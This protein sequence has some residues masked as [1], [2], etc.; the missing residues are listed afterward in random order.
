MFRKIKKQ[1]EKNKAEIISAEYGKKEEGGNFPSEQF[2]VSQLAFLGDSVYEVAVR[3]KLCEHYE[4]KAQKLHDEAVKISNAKFQS[5]AV[6]IIYPVLSE[7]EKEIYIKG[8]NL[9]TPHKP[10]SATKK[11][12]SK[13]TGLETLF[14]KL[15]EDRNFGRIEELINIILK[16]ETEE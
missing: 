16:K 9:H 1:S 12:Y 6:D 7:R 10:K 3:Q 15:W 8:R 4:E 14:G 2:G 5:R 13:A 11:E